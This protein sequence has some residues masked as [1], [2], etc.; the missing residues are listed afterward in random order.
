M[1]T[2]MAS[3]RYSETIEIQAVKIPSQMMASHFVISGDSSS[4]GI[5]SSSIDIFN[6]RN[7]NSGL[8][9]ERDRMRES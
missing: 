9:R 1:G 4:L 6:H 3:T 5:L 7:R 8:R 2:S